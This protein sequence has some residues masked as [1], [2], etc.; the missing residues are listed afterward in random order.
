MEAGLISRPRPWP[1][2]RV[3]LPAVTAVAAIT[4]VAALLRLW[5][6]SG[7]AGNPFY[8][9]AV[10]SMGQSWHNLF[11]GAFE[12]GGQAS[13]DKIPADLWLQ[14]LST[15]LL[16]FTAL[17]TR[18]PGALA[19]ALAVPLLYDLVRRVFGRTAGLAAAA[20]LALLPISVLTARSDTMDSLMML[21][22]V[23]A[24]WLIVWG[25]QRGR[26]WPLVAAGAVTGLAFN[27]KLFE[28]LLVL[29][30]LA[31]LALLAG[32]IGWR[33]RTAGL[34]GAF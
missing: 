1:Q 3:A 17:A 11:Y 20:A 15:K 28:G 7:V 14:V 30:A 27:V 19:G 6:V 2:I 16:G 24:A 26:A 18:L 34:A 8:D 32:E 25:A 23:A 29:P 31:L 21:L 4:A 22:D 12:P 10:R 9:A 33:R 13:I 5:S